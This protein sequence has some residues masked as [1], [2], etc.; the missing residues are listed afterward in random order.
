MMI[1]A[2]GDF[3]SFAVCEDELMVTGFEPCRPNV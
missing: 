3:F 2:M 1:G